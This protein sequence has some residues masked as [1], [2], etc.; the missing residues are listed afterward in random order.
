[1]RGDAVLQH[2]ISQCLD[3]VH[4][5]QAPPHLD[6]QALARELVDERHQPQAAAVFGGVVPEVITPD[7]MRIFRAQSHA[8][9]VVEPQKAPGAML[10]WYL[11]PLA[12]LDALHPVAANLPAAGLQHRR[13]APVAKAAILGRQRNNSLADATRLYSLAAPARKSVLRR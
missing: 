2:R 10:L 13:D 7:V 8:G 3:D 12:T 9:A 6:R 1:M 11:E 4:T 5:V